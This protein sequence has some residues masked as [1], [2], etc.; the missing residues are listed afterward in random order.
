[1]KNKFRKRIV[2]YCII[3]YFVTSIVEVVAEYFNDLLFIW[4]F[5]P[6]LMPLLIIYYLLKSKTKNKLFIFSLVLMWIANLF[7]I[8]T[9]MSFVII[10]SI[11][12]LAYRAIILY[13]IF[14]LV[15]LPSK[16]PM[17]IGFI[18]FLFI[19][20]TIAFLSFVELGNNIYL[21]LIHGLFIVFLGGYSFGNYMIYSTRTNLYLFLS[22][23]LFALSQFV[24]IL[25]LYS[26][27]VHMLH[28]FAMLQFIIAQFLLTKFVYLK[29]KYKHKFQITNLISE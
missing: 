17:I 15:K 1:M 8:E 22:T 13:L 2:N 6:L 26:E 25:K 20:L 28:A 27:Y 4:L 9:A 3:L 11:F 18:P 5:K 16:I 7:F 12:F 23:I 21:F 24:F 14:K 19:Y 10:G 29:E